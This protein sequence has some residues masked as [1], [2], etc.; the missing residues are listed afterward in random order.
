MAKKGRVYT[1]EIIISFRLSAMSRINLLSDVKLIKY[2]LW[3]NF[4]LRGQIRKT[5]DHDFSTNL[6]DN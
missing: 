5:K 6:I 1:D 2:Q 3:V 4:T